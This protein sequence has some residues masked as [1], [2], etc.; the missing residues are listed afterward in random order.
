MK[1]PRKK[2]LD[3]LD[4]VFSRYIRTRDNKCVLCGGK[5]GEIE[6]LQSHHW[7]V[8]RTRSNK[9]KF[10]ERNC[11]ALCYA[12]HILKI[13][14]SPTVAQIDEL[15]ERCLN[16]GIATQED[17]DEIKRDSSIIYKL[18]M[19]EIK[20]KIEY[21]KQKLKDLENEYKRK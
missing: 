13:H 10:D 6:N 17:I 18:S 14:N 2:L 8:R 16:E 3:E 11:V 21:Y 20:D 5:V 12:C 19:S 1:T 15:K 4:S 9:Y 7:I